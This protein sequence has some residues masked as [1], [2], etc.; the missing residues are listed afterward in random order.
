MDPKLAKLYQADP[1]L[2]EFDIIPI[3]AYGNCG[4]DT[5]LNGLTYNYEED[6]IMDIMNYWL[7]DDE[8]ITSI[9]LD[10]HFIKQHNI[11]RY[12][13]NTTSSFRQVLKKFYE[14][15]IR[16]PTDESELSELSEINQR[17]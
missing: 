9:N 6:E 4:V 16:V 15:L 1:V 12:A 10:K 13:L 11:I 2:K 8:K 5:L 14:D 3:A 17:K 7:D